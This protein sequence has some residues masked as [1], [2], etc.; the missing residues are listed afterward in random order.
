[1]DREVK[2]Y[3]DGELVFQGILKE[4]LEI[5]KDDMEF[6]LDQIDFAKVSNTFKEVSGEWKIEFCEI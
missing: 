4:F 3:N 6:L 2:V 1:M 5:N